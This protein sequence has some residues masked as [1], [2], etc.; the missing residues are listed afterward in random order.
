MQIQT[1]TQDELGLLI[2]GLR[3]FHI[4]DS[5]LYALKK[6]LTRQLESELSKRFGAKLA[7]PRP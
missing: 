3:T 2:N 1:V 4:T 6:K 7:E 5:R